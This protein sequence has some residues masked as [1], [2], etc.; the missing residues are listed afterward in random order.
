MHI[1][2]LTVCVAQEITEQLRGMALVPGVSGCF[3][4]GDSQGFHHCRVPPGMTCFQP[5]PGGPP[6]RASSQYGR[7]FP[8]SKLP[9]LDKRKQQKWKPVSSQK[10][11]Y[12]IS[13]ISCLLEESQQVQPTAK[14]RGWHKD[15]G[16]GVGT[17]CF[18]HRASILRFQSEIRTAVQLHYHHSSTI[19]QPQIQVLLCA[20]QS[21]SGS[22]SPPT[23][24]EMW[25]HHL[26]EDQ[27]QTLVPYAFTCKGRKHF[28][29]VCIKKDNIFVRWESLKISRGWLLLFFLQ[30]WTE[31][32]E[33]QGSVPFL[34]VLL[35]P[36][37][38]IRSLFME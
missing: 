3:H 25:S 28:L 30:L 15:M 4:Q 35:P 6:H 17:I 16:I 8:S 14:G 13:A 7:G 1:Y 20:M 26:R 5:P 36:S 31:D 18:Q 21:K 2:Y 12:I 29:G 32:V 38:I 22:L 33:S 24:F 19:Q 23:A 11:C 37:K 9:W 34:Y 10:G 27:M